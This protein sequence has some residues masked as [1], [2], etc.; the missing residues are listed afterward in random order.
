V[1]TVTLKDFQAFAQQRIA[2]GLSNPGQ[3]SAKLNEVF[4]FAV[5]NEN[6]MDE[7]ANAY[8]DN[9]LT[10]LTD[11]IEH[12]LGKLADSSEKRKLQ[13]LVALT[14]GKHHRAERLAEGLGRPLP[15]P[16]AVAEA[17]KPIFLATL[18]SVLDVLFDATLQPRTEKN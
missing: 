2:D 5:A 8:F 13:R 12:G 7:E 9:V 15:R 6:T 11:I 16:F 17:A 10:G 3:F 1:A 14:R 4:D 18:Q